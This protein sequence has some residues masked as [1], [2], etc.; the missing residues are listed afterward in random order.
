MDD[1]T[2]TAAGAECFFHGEQQ[3]QQRAISWLLAYGASGYHQRFRSAV[4]SFPDQSQRRWR[5][6]RVN[7]SS[8]KKS[9][10]LDGKTRPRR[11]RW[12]REDQELPDW[13]SRLRTLLIYSWVV[14]WGT[15][16]THKHTHTQ[17]LQ[18]IHTMWPWHSWKNHRLLQEK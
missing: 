1:S 12:L 13:S 16:I 8:T 14:W 4:G 17:G 3:Q 10:R 11:P 7:R 5:C 6:R 2:A 15:D 9:S 18:L